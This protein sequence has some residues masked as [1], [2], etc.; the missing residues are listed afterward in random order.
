V[1]KELQN[2]LYAS[3]PKIFAQKD[4]DMKRTA[5]CWGIS[6]G[7]GWYNILEVLCGELQSYVDEPHRNV[8][9]YTRF[10]E[11][12]T[13]N[14]DDEAV[15]MWEQKLQKAK[16]SIVPQV[17]AVQV[18]EKYGTLRFYTNVYD[19]RINSLT[20]FAESMSACTCEDC[21]SPGSPDPGGWIKT[22][23]DNCRGEL[24]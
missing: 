16:K 20:G 17:E 11:E 15:K 5:M 23:C 13:L 22:R 2:K 24:S 19:D 7:D 8:E 6:C 3:Y 10:L 14:E 21:G 1:R 12:A 18:K 4:L 9:L